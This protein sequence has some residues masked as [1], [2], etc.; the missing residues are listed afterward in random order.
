[1]HERRMSISVFEK[2][3]FFLTFHELDYFQNE[4]LQNLIIHHAHNVGL[5][6]IYRLER[7]YWVVFSVSHCTW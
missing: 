4:N 7:I 3:W 6:V 1:M 5:L 2:K